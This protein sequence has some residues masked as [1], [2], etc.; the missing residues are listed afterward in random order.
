VGT[1]V[2]TGI[3]L[4][5][6]YTPGT[7]TSYHSIVHIYREVYSGSIHRYTHSQVASL[8]YTGLL[9][10]VSRGVFPGSYWYSTGVV[11]MGVGLAGALMAIGYMGYILPW[12]QMSY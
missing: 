11:W 12:G 7:C 5:L 2:L 4:G 6:H 8:V 3:L 1:Q 9:V 10:H